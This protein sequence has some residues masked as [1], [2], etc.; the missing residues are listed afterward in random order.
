MLSTT[1]ILI[2]AKEL[3]NKPNGYVKH[4]LADG[5]GGYCAL[6]ACLA[7]GHQAQTGANVSTSGDCL[8]MTFLPAYTKANML[9]AR[10]S[11]LPFRANIV[12]YNNHPARTV[13]EMNQVFCKAIEIAAEE[14][15]NEQ[16][17]D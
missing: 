12:G 3:L 14:E 1:E 9:L 8:S 17:T 4:K 10:V 15:A 11:P 6:G 7:A 2:K 16:A 5:M 13:E